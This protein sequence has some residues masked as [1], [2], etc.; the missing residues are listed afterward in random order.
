[1]LVYCLD[2]RPPYVGQQ[3][4]PFP[5]IKLLTGTYISQRN[6]ICL[7][8][9]RNSHASS[10]CGDCQRRSSAPLP[11]KLAIPVL[12]VL[13]SML[14]GDT[15][16]SFWN[17]RSGVRSPEN[18]LFASWMTISRNKSSRPE[19]RSCGSGGPQLTEPKNRMNVPAEK[20]S[21][22]PAGVQPSTLWEPLLPLLKHMCVRHVHKNPLSFL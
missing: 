19:A 15:A 17:C 13:S 14:V 20:V 10:V 4:D 18:W 2:V 6:S 1:M 16:K 5:S 3:W 11:G 7:S 9:R 21:E 12:A 8:D 22:I